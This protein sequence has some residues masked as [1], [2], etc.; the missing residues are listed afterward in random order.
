MSAI[1]F[2]AQYKQSILHKTKNSTIRIG[3]EIDKYKAGETY[4]VKSYAGKHWNVKIKILS[5]TKT[6]LCCLSNHNIP[7]RSIKATQRKEKILSDEPVEIIRFVV[8]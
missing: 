8:V 4:S 5:I 6:K 2:P 1:S 3:E 7:K